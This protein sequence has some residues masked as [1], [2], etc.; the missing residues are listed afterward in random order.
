MIAE[1]NYC[2]VD[3]LFSFHAATVDK[4]LISKRGGTQLG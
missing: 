2:A 1:R 3:V 4:A